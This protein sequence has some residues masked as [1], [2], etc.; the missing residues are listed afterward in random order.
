MKKSHILTAAAAAA[1]LALSACGGGSGSGDSQ[2]SAATSESAA[3]GAAYSI[4]ITQLLSHPSLDQSREGFMDALKEAGVNATYDEKNAQGDQ[5]TAAD[6]AGSFASGNYDLILAIATPT[7]Q[8]TAQAISDKPILFTAVTDPVDAGLVKSMDAPG[9]NITG[10]SDANPVKEQLELIKEI[11]P[12]AKKIG[13]PYSPGEANSLVQVQWAKDAAAGLGLEIVEGPATTSADVLQA[14]E[15]LKDTDAIYVPTDNIV[16]AA[17]ETVLQFGETNKIPVY[18][19]EGDSVERGA[20]ATVG[21]S[22]YELGKQTG[23]MAVKILKDGA[24]P[25]TMPVETQK[26]TVLYVNEGAAKRMDVTIPQS[27]LDKVAPENLVK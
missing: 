17:L 24:D 15:S 20:L 19:A 8:A 12:D 2:S 26:E 13:V 9:A 27:V 21:L 3:D 16:V 5:S 14:V 1:A 6:I 23:E 25:A 11:N 10:T 22:Y 4:G 18:G 7:A